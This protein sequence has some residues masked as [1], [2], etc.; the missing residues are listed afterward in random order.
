[1][2]SFFFASDGRVSRLIWAHH[3]SSPCLRL[4]QIITNYHKNSQKQSKTIEMNGQILIFPSKNPHF[5]I[6]GST[7]R[8]YLLMFCLV[9]LAWRRRWWFV[10]LN[11]QLIIFN[12]K[13]II[14]NPKF[15]IL[16]ESAWHFSIA[17]ACWRWYIGSTPDLIQKHGFLN[18]KTSFVMQK[19]SF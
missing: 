5:S 3:T 15:I 1:M 8:A 17:R 6:V 10:I 4:S 16:P 13:F 7:A 12:P 9:Q 18:A 2:S 11:P 19:S 14:V